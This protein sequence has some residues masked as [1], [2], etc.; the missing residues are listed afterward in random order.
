LSEGESK[1]EQF[2]RGLHIVSI[3]LKSC[4]ATLD[5]D[6]LFTLM[7]GKD[8][9]M[10]VFKDTY[11]TT[12]VGSNFFEASGAFI[13]TVQESQT[14]QPVLSVECEFEA[15]LHGLEPIAKA[16]VDRFVSTEFRLILVPFARQFVSSTTAQMSIPPLV[17]PLSIG[18]A[19]K[20]N[21]MARPK[22]TSRKHAKAR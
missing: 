15:H 14:S 7:D 20:S 16:N 13:V 5:R 3:G 4:H 1:Y 22:R 2:L 8:G 10:R 11:K 19:P 12:R 18:P 6:G 17:I 21:I 9:P